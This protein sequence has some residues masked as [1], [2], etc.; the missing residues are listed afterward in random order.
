MIKAAFFD[1]DGTLI[2]KTTDHLIPQST[3]DALIELR[4]NGIKLFI[5]SGRTKPE[6]PPCIREG[7]PGFEDSFDGYISL[8]GSYCMD[9]NGVYNKD[10]ISKE[11]VA[12]VYRLVEKGEF[13]ALALF[14][15]RS[16]ANELTPEILTVAEMVGLTYHA[17]DFSQVL[18]EDVFQFCAF[19]P[20]EKDAWLQN[21][22]PGCIITRWCPYFCDVIPASSSKH[23]G[24]AATCKR[25]GFTPEECIAFGDGGNDVTMLKFVGTGVAMGNAVEIA[26]DAADYVTTDVDKDGIPNALRHF[27][28]IS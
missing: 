17:E 20:P 22:M 28:L 1:I 4:K 2:D 12:E 11:E 24:I 13:S 14:P 21:I 15:D 6:M 16:F 3:K 19:I 10:V 25:F 23:K 26:K 9:H 7:F 18:T 8:N 27:G 5:S